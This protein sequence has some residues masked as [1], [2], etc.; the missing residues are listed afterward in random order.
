M[1]YFSNKMI[2]LNCRSFDCSRTIF[3]K[4]KQYQVVQPQMSFVLL[5]RKVD[6]ASPT[7][8]QN[9]KNLAAGLQKVCPMVIF[10][11]FSAKA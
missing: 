2:H 10:D 4:V 7:A 1:F 6:G 9:A 8:P 11:C 5:I 3:F